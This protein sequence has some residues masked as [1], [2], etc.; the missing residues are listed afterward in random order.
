[1]RGGSSECRR[2]DCDA[3]AAS[4]K[5]QQG[6]N[7]THLIHDGS[8]Q[9]V[10]REDLVYQLPERSFRREIDEALAA[11]RFQPYA[12]I[13]S[14]LMLSGADRYERVLSIRNH[15][16]TGPLLLA[17]HCME[18]EIDISGSNQCRDRLGW[19][20][21]DGEFDLGIGGAKSLQQHRKLNVGCE[22][23]QNPE[24]KA[25]SD[26]S[27]LRSDCLDSIVQHC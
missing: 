7:I 26:D 23:L 20:G 24:M 12:A 3:K 2:Y 11:E 19:K 15:L 9:M 10:L 5:V 1:M 13:A 4:D 22:A 6:L 21:S 27:V 14:Q 25:A 16:E 8:R 17:D 18:A